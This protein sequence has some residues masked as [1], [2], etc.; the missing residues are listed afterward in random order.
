MSTKNNLGFGRRHLIRKGLG[1]A[2]GV[3]GV[4]AAAPFATTAFGQSCGRTPTQTRGPF[5]PVDFSLGVDSDLTKVEGR[6]AAASGRVIY[7]R[8]VVRD[9]NCVPVSNATVEIWQ[10]AAS[11]RYSHPGDDSGL[12][13]DPNFQGFGRVQTD[14]LGRWVFKTIK[15]GKYPAAP[16]WE[17]PPHIHFKVAKRGFRELI[18][19]MYF[20]GDPLNDQDRVLLDL[21]PAERASVI[22]EL[23]APGP[24]MDPQSQQCNFPITLVRLV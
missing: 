14:E 2:G 10:A 9:Q 16:G 7:V 15:P 11:G 21:S 12:E 8:G 13:V 23:N 17:R 5:Y 1:F 20:A 3:L 4:A 6:V 24:G 22:V 18:T 19:Q